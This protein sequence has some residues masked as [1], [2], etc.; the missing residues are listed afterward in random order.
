[1]QIVTCKFSPRDA[2]EY[3]YE[4]TGEGRLA[5]GDKVTVETKRGEAVV[6]VAQVDVHRPAF[7][8][9]PITGRATQEAML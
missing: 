1:M 5:P 7:P 9:K 3:T 8:L 4:W 6:V 2:R